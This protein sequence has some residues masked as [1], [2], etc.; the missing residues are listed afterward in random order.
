MLDAR[1]YEL[2]VC[3]RQKENVGRAAKSV[4]DE[5]ALSTPFGRD[6]KIEAFRAG[7]DLVYRISNDLSY[8]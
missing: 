4:M 5:I 6:D 3:Y 8:P 7:H 2:K 1:P